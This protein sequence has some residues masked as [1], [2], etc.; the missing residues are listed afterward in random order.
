MY[1]YLFRFFVMTI[2]ILSANLL[3]GAISDYLASYRNQ[4]K[5]LVFTMVGMGIIVAVF[6]PLFVKLEG[7]VKTLSVKV[8][9]SGKTFG[10]RY[11][12]LILTFLVCVTV[13]TY[14]YMRMWYDI[15]LIRY[16]IP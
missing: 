15:D 14:F 16:I 9:K 1:R 10:G 6:Y 4:Y 2:T 8:I 11:L 7:W 3:T 12:G 5:P 13:L